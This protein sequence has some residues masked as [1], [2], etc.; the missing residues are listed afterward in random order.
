VKNVLKDAEKKTV[1]FNLD[2]GT[3][4]M[5]NKDSISRKVTTTLGNIVKKGEHDYHIGD[6]E[7]EI[8][9]IL[10][11]SK[12]EFLGNATKKYFNNKNVNDPKNDTMYTIPVRMDFKDK[13]SRINAEISLRKICKVNCAVP[14]PKK[15]RLML[16]EVV[17]EGRKLAPNSF[18]RTRV[19][20]DLLIIEALAKGEKGWKDLGIKRDIPL[21]ILDANVTNT[22]NMDVMDVSPTSSEVVS[23]S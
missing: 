16:T 11:C 20:S 10:S 15:L 8:D 18:I 7:D 21:T 14:Y 1:I 2:L 4:K 6:A 13:E 22:D 17:N 19:N 9:D 23:V 3:S 12:L 5:M